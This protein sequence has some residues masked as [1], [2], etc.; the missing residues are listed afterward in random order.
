MEVTVKDE[1][2]DR[3]QAIKL[4]LAGRAVD[5]IC[6]A[7]GHSHDWF[8]TWWRRYQAMGVTGLYDQSVAPCG[9]GWA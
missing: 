7:L 2:S 3:H 5:E 4:R 1:F 9:L 8:H 6:Q